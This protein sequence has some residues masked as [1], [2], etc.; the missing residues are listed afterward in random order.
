MTVQRVKTAS[1]NHL[2]V[3]IILVVLLSLSH[4][5][6]LSFS[7]SLPL[8]L[9]VSLAFY[10]YMYFIRVCSK[11]RRDQQTY[12]INT[13]G[14]TIFATFSTARRFYNLYYYVLPVTPE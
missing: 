9:P 8:Y 3:C 10:F 13:N 4:S 1:H 7:H 6:S 5:L 11:K 2:F 12:I 14:C